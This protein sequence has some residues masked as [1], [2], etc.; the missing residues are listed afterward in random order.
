MQENSERWMELAEQATVE[1][2]PDKL[3][4]LVL[5]INKLLE[6]KQK[7]LTELRLGHPP[8]KQNE[9]PLPH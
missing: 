1:Q 4:A 5:E 2:D 7:R 9:V 3:M 8:P 6:E